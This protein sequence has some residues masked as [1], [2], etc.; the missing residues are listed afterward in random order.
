[1]PNITTTLQNTSATKDAINVLPKKSTI[2]KQIQRAR[3][4]EL[5]VPDAPKTWQGFAIPEVLTKTASGDQF[6]ILEERLEDDRDEYIVG[7]ASPE[8]IKTMKDSTQMFGDGTFEVV[9]KTLFYQVFVIISTTVTG[10]NVPTS[11]FL[12]PCKEAIVYKKALMCLKNLG[13]TDPPIFHCDFENN[14]IKSIKDVYPVVGSC[15]ATDTSNV[16]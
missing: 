15:A 16:P 13:V 7:F 5:D 2:A 11:Y 9:E 3:Q 1:M 12:L 8:G 10:I 14:I 6:L 4:K